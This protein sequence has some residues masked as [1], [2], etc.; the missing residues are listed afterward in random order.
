[1]RSLR[2]AV[3]VALFAAAMCGASTALANGRFPRASMLI[4]DS[5]NPSKLTIAATYGLLITEDRGRHWYYVCDQAFSFQLLL[6]DPVAA[7]VADGSLLVGSWTTIAMS[8]DRAT[9]Q[10]SAAH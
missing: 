10:S 2:I 6:V 9:G 5:S 4:E 8:R 3:T 7:Q 1:V